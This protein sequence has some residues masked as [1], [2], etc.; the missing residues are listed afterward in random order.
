MQHDDEKQDDAVEAPKDEVEQELDLSKL[1]LTVETIEERISPS[2]TN[3][4]DK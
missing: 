1:D 2:E 4:F 3:V